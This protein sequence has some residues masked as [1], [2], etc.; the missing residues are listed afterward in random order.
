MELRD[1]L[2]EKM[3]RL[4]KNVIS[5]YTGIGKIHIL[6]LSQILGVFLEY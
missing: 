1:K 3:E 2:T 6:V 5:M 4:N